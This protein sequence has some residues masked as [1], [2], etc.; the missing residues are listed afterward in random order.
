MWIIDKFQTREFILWR[1]QMKFDLVEMSF[2]YQVNKI[3]GTYDM[4]LEGVKNCI[5]QIF[6]IKHFSNVYWT[7]HLIMLYQLTMKTIQ[8]LKGKHHYS[9]TLYLCEG[10]LSNKKDVQ[11]SVCWVQSK[12]FIRNDTEGWKLTQVDLAACATAVALLLSL[13]HN[14]QILF[15]VSKIAQ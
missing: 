14:S 7:R 11:H 5:G 2:L 8:K 10:Q 6:L 1:K 3:V 15:L 9:R 4:R 12:W 13:K